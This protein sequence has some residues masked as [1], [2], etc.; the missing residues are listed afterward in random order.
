M[1]NKMQ[2]DG[3]LLQNASS[4]VAVDTFYDRRSGFEFMTNPLGALFD[5]A[6]ANEGT[7]INLD[8]NTVWHS[9]SARLRDGWNTE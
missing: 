9:R 5:L 8:W 1:A 7:T 2:R 4:A 3:G 6:F